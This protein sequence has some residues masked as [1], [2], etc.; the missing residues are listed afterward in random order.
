MCLV[1]RILLGT[2]HICPTRA[3]L[4]IC[5]Q[6]IIICMLI[7]CPHMFSL[8]HSNASM[9][10]VWLLALFV[11]I[12]VHIV[13]LQ[14]SI[15]LCSPCILLGALI[16]YY[17]TLYTI[18]PSSPTPQHCSGDELDEDG[19]VLHPKL[20]VH[21]VNFNTAACLLSHKLGVSFFCHLPTLKPSV[22]EV[23]VPWNLFIASFPLP[24]NDV[25][26]LS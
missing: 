25:Y 1:A 17:Y 11:L 21:L 3:W 24:M 23:L 19:E 22:V 6:K 16:H 20:T 14:T 9:Q 26:H 13:W 2:L 5:M 15:Q 18:I 12:W 8:H 4:N 10:C 7:D